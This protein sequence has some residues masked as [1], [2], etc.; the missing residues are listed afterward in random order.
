MRKT[1]LYLRELLVEF[2]EETGNMYN[3][4]AVPGEGTCYRLAR[5]D[6]D[7][8]GDN[9]YLS[10]TEENPYYTNSTQLPVW[11]NDIWFALQHQN[12]LQP[13]YTGGTV[14]HVFVGEDLSNSTKSVQEFVRLAFTKTKIPYL[15]ITPTFSVCPNHGFVEG[16]HFNCPKCGEDCSIY[17]RVVG[18][19]RPVQRW[20][21]GKKE[22]FKDRNYFEIL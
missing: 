21:K 7:M 14:L 6:R 11:I 12:E 22:E 10:G 3:L 17:S 19:Y 15:S 1:L 18:Y 9:I 20:N 2:Q 4:E 5:I 13:L 8:Y 16:E